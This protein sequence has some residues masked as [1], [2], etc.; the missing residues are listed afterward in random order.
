MKH[1]AIAQLYYNQVIAKKRELASV[2]AKWQE[3]VRE[4]I[5]EAGLDPEDY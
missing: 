4:M 5:T 3:E 1:S 2:P